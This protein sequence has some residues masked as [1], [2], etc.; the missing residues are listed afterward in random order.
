MTSRLP[1]DWVP[2]VARRQ[3]GLFTRRQAI[4]AGATPAQ[5]RHRR[6]IGRWVTVVGDALTL[7]PVEA[8]GWLR[9]QAAALTWPDSVAC[10]TSA[11]VLHRLPVPDSLSAHVIVPNHRPSRGGIVTHE[12][13]LAADEVTRHGLAQVTTLRRTLYD[14][15]GRLPDDASEQLVAWAIS[16][17]VLDAKALDAAMRSRPRAWGD[18]RRRRALLASASGAVSAAERRLHRIL[19]RAGISGWEADQRIDVEGWV[20]ARADVLFRAERLVIEVDGYAFH[21]R[22]RFQEDRTRQNRLVAHGYTVLR[23]TWTD[24]TQRPDDVSAQVRAT[25]DLLRGRWQRATS[26]PDRRSP[27]AQSGSRP[28]AT[29][30]R[31]DR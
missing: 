12:L 3:A 11:A 24:L 8:D 26:R 13:T 7:A 25:L 2:P 1:K 15:I 18:A 4:A 20:I 21:G 23:F 14:C 9:A 10:L 5:V 17:D 22:Q 27:G 6:E 16:R 31:S 28:P 30:F 29:T 19:R